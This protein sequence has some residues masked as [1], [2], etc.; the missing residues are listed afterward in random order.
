MFSSNHFINSLIIIFLNIV[1][2]KNEEAFSYLLLSLINYR[3][4]IE[5]LPLVREK[6][7]I[8]LP[9]HLTWYDSCF[10]SVMDQELPILNPS[11]VNHILMDAGLKDFKINDDIIEV[12]SN[13][14]LYLQKHFNLISNEEL[15]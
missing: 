4:S 12:G 3:N 13:S 7:K 14:R 5:F 1:K 6:I 8:H 10:D 9:S 15:N 2:D 11:D